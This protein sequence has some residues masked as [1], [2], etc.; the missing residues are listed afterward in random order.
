MV[1]RAEHAAALGQTGLGA[2]LPKE[3]DQVTRWQFI[4]FG[5]AEPLGLLA[6]AQDVLGDGSLVV[7]DASGVTAGG[8]AVFVQLPSGPVLLCGNLAWTREQYVYTRLPGL[9]FDRSAW[10]DKIWRVK[11]WSQLAPELTVLPDH[12]WRTVEERATA[13]M[14][15]HIFGE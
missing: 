14:Q 2:Y 13:D 6:A 5:Q 12:D 10:W 4:D 11:K 7:L 8:L 15:L 3:Y 9:A 1:S